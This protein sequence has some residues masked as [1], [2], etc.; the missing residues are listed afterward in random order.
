MQIKKGGT[1]EEV[2]EEETFL[3]NHLQRLSFVLSTHKVIPY[4]NL[5][6]RTTNT[7]KIPANCTIYWKRA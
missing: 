6:E 3:Q 5:I 7:L 2:E 4:L 1:R